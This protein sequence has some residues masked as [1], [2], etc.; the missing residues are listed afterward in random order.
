MKPEPLT[1][2]EKRLLISKWNEI[3]KIIPNNLEMLVLSE[4]KKDSVFSANDVS[5]IT[6]IHRINTHKLLN[7]LADKG[8]LIL[9]YGQSLYGT[10]S[11]VFLLQ[12]G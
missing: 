12:R 11:R 3:S 10:K 6:G 1:I 9:G 7:G 4:F 2:D 5:I 8:W